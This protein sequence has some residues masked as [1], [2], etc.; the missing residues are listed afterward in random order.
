MNILDK[1][2]KKEEKK[3]RKHGKKIVIDLG[4]RRIVKI[5]YDNDGNELPYIPKRLVWDYK[6][7]LKSA[8]WRLNRLIGAYPRHYEYGLTKMFIK[9]IDKLKIDKLTKKGLL[10]NDT[11]F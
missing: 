11:I 4:R 10:V 2:L 9:H 8:I 3:L 1:I 7:P 5:E 6:T